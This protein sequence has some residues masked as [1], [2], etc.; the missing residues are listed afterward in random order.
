MDLASLRQGFAKPPKEAGPWVY[1]FW[2]DNAVTRDEIT[3]ELEEMAAAGLAGAEIR[4]VNAEWL[5]ARFKTELPQTGHK[6]L[7]YLS[8]EFLQCLEH[9]CATASKLGLKLGLNL[10]MGWPPGGTWITEPHRSKMLV[11]EQ[12]VIQGGKTVDIAVPKKFTR[13]DHA[14]LAGHRLLEVAVPQFCERPKHVLAWRL[15]EAEAK[16]IAP[17]SLVNLTGALSSDKQALRWDAPAGDWVVG[18]FGVGLG[19]LLD[20]ATGYPADPGSAEAMRFHLNHIFSRLDPV[21]GKYYGTTLTDIASDSW[22]YDGRPAWTPG[23]E[24]EFK[25]VSGYELAPFMHVLLGYGPDA[26]KVRTDLERTENALVQRHY[27]QLITS[28]VNQRGLRHR[29][30]PRGRGLYRDFFDS[31]AH[32][33]IPEVEQETIPAEA[34]WVAHCLGK[35]VVSIEAFTFLSHYNSML[36]EFGKAFGPWQV[37]PDLLRRHANLIFATGINRIQMHSFGYSPPGLE[38]PGWRMYAEIH[39]NRNVVWW[40]YMGLLS[41]WMARNQFALQSGI[42]VADA[43][44]YPVTVNPPE[45]GIGELSDKQPAL[46]LNAVDGLCRSLFEKLKKGRPDGSYDFNHLVLIDG[47]QS[48]AEVEHL[49]ALVDAGAKVVCCTSLP[50]AWD[51]FKCPATCDTEWASQALNR[52]RAAQKTGAFLDA[53]GVPWKNALEKVRSVTWSPAAAALSFQHRRVS[54]GELYL[55]VNHGQLFDGEVSFPYPLL[56][57]ELWDADTGRTE[58]AGEVRREAGRTFVKLHLE[59]Y[60]STL[61]VFSERPGASLPAAKPRLTKRTALPE[62]LPVR[63]PWALH[64]DKSR[65]QGLATS[66]DLTLDRLVSWRDLPLLERCAGIVTYTAQLELPKD[67][68]GADLGWV[69]ELGAVYELARVTL[70]GK[71]VG[72]SWTQPY[73]IDVTGFLHDG[74]NTLELV[75]PNLLEDGLEQAEHTRPSGLLGPVVLRPYGTFRSQ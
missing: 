47:L 27:F 10:G 8:P 15:A 68:V 66:V 62:A 43:V 19:G 30:Q 42:P 18:F 16:T 35:P 46:A 3:R 59:P 29:P 11:C 60:N 12:V 55:L 65:C 51:V 37:N 73:R 40:P 57:P 28:F 38:L 1:W 70:N 63:G 25:N 72:T 4:C 21:I 31:Y 44:V 39:L 54:G 5:R 32:C 14:P 64:A 67:S 58:V 2:W 50:E 20:K 17:S 7:E 26:D 71:S 53:H 41:A 36:G 69:L 52:L 6:P 13:Q 9:A 34:T 33:D 22:E 74:T 45:K 75:V 61:V 49:L 23:L 48:R 56:T 24:A